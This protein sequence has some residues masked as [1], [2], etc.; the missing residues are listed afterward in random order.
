MADERAFSKE[1]GDL[2]DRCCNQPSFKDVPK[3][4]WLETARG[5]LEN[6][7]EKTAWRLGKRMR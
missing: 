5:L 4:I 6:I 7:K 2:P 3:E 1:K